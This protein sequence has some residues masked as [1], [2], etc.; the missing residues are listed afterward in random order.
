MSERGRSPAP[1]G[2]SSR[3]GSPAPSAGKSPA[4]YPPALGSDPGRLQADKKTNTRIELGPEAYIS[5]NADKFTERGQKYNTEG[6]QDMVGSNQYRMK[7]FDFSKK[8][9]QYDVIITP[10]DR[11]TPFK[12]IMAHRSVQQILAPYTPELWLFDGKKLAW[13][14]GKVDRGEIRAK[15]DLDEDERPAGETPRS[16]A[17]FNVALRVTTEINLSVLQAY[18]EKKT[19]FSSKVI[20][21][22]SF[23]D[24]L[25]RQGPSEKLLSIKK[26]FYNT[27][28][29]SRP[30]VDG[31]LL[32]VH[33]GL[34]A[35]IR[36]SHNLGQGGVGLALNCDVA[37]T[38]FWVSGESLEQVI[39]YFLAAN[40][41][42]KYM[43]LNPATTLAQA[44]KPMKTPQGIEMTDAM[45]QLRK[46][47]KLKFKV[48]CRN[49]PASLDDKVYTLMD[50]SFDKSGNLGP[51]G[52]TA[53]TVNFDYNGKSTSIAEYY[54]LRYGYTIKYSNLPLVET[55]KDAK[56]PME[57]CYIEP[58]QRYNLKLTPKQTESMI[59][60]AVTKPPQRKADIELGVK[61]LD[62]PNDRLMKYYGATFEQQFSQ[63]QARI[64]APPS[65]D[66]KVGKQEPRFGGRW[67]LD[68]GNI[69]FW[70]ANT[71]PLKNWGFIALNNCVPKQALDAFGRKFKQILEKHGVVAPTPPM[72]LE[73]PGNARDT[74][75]SIE[76]AHGE[77]TKARGYTQ[78]LCIIVGFK[79]DPS[80]ERI[81]KNSDCRFGFLSQCMVA[82]HLKKESGIDQYVSNVAMKVNAK[83]GGA[84]SRTVSP[85]GKGPTYFPPNRKTMIIGADISHPGP[86]SETAS[87]AAFTMNMDADA[88]RYGAAVESNGYRTEMIKAP[89][90]DKFMATLGGVWR[91][92]HGNGVPDHIMYFRDGVAENQ[93]AA[94]LDQE[95]A[96]MRNFFV[97]RN[98]KPLP[99]FTVIVATKRHH[100]RFFPG[101]DQR[102]KGGDQNGNSKPGL[103]VEREVTHPSLWD[104]Y[105][106]SHKAIQGTARPVHY[107]VIK[108]EMNCPPND[109]QRM[110]YHQCYSYARSTTPVSMHPAVY[111][112]H[113]AADRARAH[114]NVATSQGFRAYGKGHEVT[115]DR[116]AKGQTI[117]GTGDSLKNAEAP[118]LLPLGG[119]VPEGATPDEKGIRTF[120]KTTMWF[121]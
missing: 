4:G 102:N 73:I 46:L 88:N 48:R 115:R 84:T 39:C 104:F 79:N 114:E 69:K 87:I 92:S 10:E 67:R 101:P 34:Y 86:G 2:T 93:F 91:Q 23:V 80:Y 38:A 117:G 85:F 8:I 64:L 43:G 17:V 18:L 119:Q 71:V 70:K 107:Y 6:V 105:L 61:E 52:A 35:S 59:K 63:V 58:M 65:V 103:L 11:K 26:N 96:A 54:R 27:G 42:K 30:L 49:R 74:A 40:D 81:K 77:I 75:K 82:D 53:K 57:L 89:N 12:K 50:I 32:E 76:W 100:I 14:P 47:R 113:L 120:M 112:A 3:Q 22:L 116:I 37:N 110:I 33:K 98:V 90:I 7:T 1:S 19:S 16:G 106:N 28:R 31:K 51:E 97:S 21:A 78:L 108:D 5:G 44:L 68:Q 62:L 15:V 118:P 109:L 111:Y 94:V 9:Y 72:I 45:K 66:F 13:A 20:E 24:H 55:A 41:P 25:L 60:I 83:L 29:K 56:F 99:K 36:L 95:V 121:I